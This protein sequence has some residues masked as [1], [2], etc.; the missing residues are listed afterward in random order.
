M[1]EL[2]RRTRWLLAFLFAYALLWVILTIASPN[3]GLVTPDGHLHVASAVL[4]GLTLILRLLVLFVVTP[5]LVY[6]LMFAP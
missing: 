5:L 2:W 3:H 1:K 6:R 4:T